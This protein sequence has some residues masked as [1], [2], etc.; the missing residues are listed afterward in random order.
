MEMSLQDFAY[1]VLE[2][3]GLGYSLV[4]KFGPDISHI[5]DDVKLQELWK[6]ASLAVSEVEDYLRNV[7][8]GDE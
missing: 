5:V 2:S 3:E 8:E 1:Y 4:G 6:K 7:L